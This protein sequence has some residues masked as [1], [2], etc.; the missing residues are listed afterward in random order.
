MVE[1]Y[2]LGAAVIYI[3]L[4][5][6]SSLYSIKNYLIDK[7]ETPKLAFSLLIGNFGVLVVFVSLIVAFFWPLFI[8]GTIIFF[9]TWTIRNKWKENLQALQEF[10]R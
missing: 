7:K 1:I 5:V 8:P 2:Y 10:L 9:I 4:A 3:V 6:I